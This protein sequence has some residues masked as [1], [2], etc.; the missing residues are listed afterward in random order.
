MNII[1]S[2]YFKYIIVILLFGIW[3]FFFDDYK[4]S[5]QRELKSQLNELQQEL[6]EIRKIKEDYET[7]NKLIKTN[8]EL[9]ETIGRDNYYMKRDDEDLFIFLKEDEAGKLVRVE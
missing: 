2:K 4:L 1:K 5:K 3:I 8:Q 9:V 6:K 7:K